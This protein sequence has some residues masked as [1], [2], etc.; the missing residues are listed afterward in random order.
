MEMQVMNGL[1]GTVPAVGDYA[2]AVLHAHFGGQL[3][4]DLKDVP[5]HSGI[6]AVYLGSRLYVLLGDNKEVGGCLG[7]NVVEGVAEIILIHLF[8]GHLTAYYAA[9]KTVVHIIAPLLS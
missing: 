5:Y 6:G 7:V 3:C 1:T 2:E 9:E 8:G 4:D